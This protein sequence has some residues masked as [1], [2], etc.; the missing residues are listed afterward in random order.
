MITRS[1]LLLPHGLSNLGPGLAW[2]DVDGDGDFDYY[3][4]KGEGQIGEVRFNDGK[5][6]F[7]ARFSPALR[8]DKGGADFAPLFFDADGDGEL[9]LFIGGG[10]YR[11]APAIPSSATGFI[12]MT[13]RE[14]FTRA[15]DALPVDEQPAGAVCAADFD[16]D[17]DLDLFVGDRVIAEDYPLPADGRILR[18]DSRDG[19]V[20][21]TDVTKTWRRT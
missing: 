11:F 7:I 1:R 17:G 20:R 21:F 4:R 19:K 5:G 8:A 16:R 2:G 18:N 9:D 13:A 6:R 15:E 12:S 14:I 10:S 3:V